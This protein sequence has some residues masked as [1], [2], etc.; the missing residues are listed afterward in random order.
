MCVLV[1]ICVRMCVCLHLFSIVDVLWCPSI[2]SVCVLRCSWFL[3]D[4]LCKKEPLASS[5]FFISYEWVLLVW[6]G[7]WGGGRVFFLHRGCA[8]VSSL[9]FLCVVCIVTD[10]FDKLRNKK[11]KSI[12]FL[13]P[14]DVY[15]W[16][17]LGGW[18]VSVIVL[19]CEC[20][21][22]VPLNFCVFCGLHCGRFIDFIWQIKKKKYRFYRFPI[23]FNSNM[24]SVTFFLTY[25]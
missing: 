12:Y 22:G 15:G 14:I 16:F 5:Q 13:S 21:E 10:I 4:K 25:N 23:H 20:V 17:I 18:G 2:I 19:H 6:G 7:G 1:C 24:I 3:F 11:K 9:Q 8:V